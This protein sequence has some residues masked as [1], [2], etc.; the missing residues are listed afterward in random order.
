M[1]F[2]A[3]KI[4]DGF[5]R[6]FHYLRLSVTEVCNFSCTYCLP[7]GW[8]KTGPL[9]F[10]T[11]DEIGRLVAGFSDLGL[12]KVRLT[13]GEP[14]VRKDFNA[15]IQT[16]ASAPG[17]AKVAMTTNGWNLAR[18]ATDWRA[19][20]L[21]HINVS[22]D[23]IDPQTFH[24]ITGHDKLNQVLTGLDLALAEG[25]SAVKVNAVLLRE[26]AEAGFD[27]WARFVRDRPVAV[28]FIELMKTTDNDA[29]FARHHVKAQGL[30]DWLDQNGWT[31]SERAFDAGPALEY[32]HPDHAGAIGLIAPYAPGFCDSCNRLRVTARG[33]LRLCLFGDGGVDLRDLL[34]DDDDRE[35]LTQRI[36]SSL[37]GK[38]VGHNLAL[39]RSGD[40]RNLAQLG[41]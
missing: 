5:G 13:G 22:I 16:V 35:A 7:N 32:R 1:A 25:Y 39:G 34:Q 17:V 26:T 28:R 3:G 38:S 19:S 36:M 20:G 37:G 40:L 29:Y 21:S 33:K 23:S 10:L 24:Q 41:G 14:T 31:P 11:V 15:I 9:S 30:R 6:R 18:H 8:K 4:T 27:G 2:D 12:S